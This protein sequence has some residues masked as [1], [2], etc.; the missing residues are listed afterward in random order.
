MLMR[1][2]TFN[3]WNLGP[4]APA[5][6]QVAKSIYNKQDICSMCK[7]RKADCRRSIETKIRKTLR[8]SDELVLYVLNL[9][10]GLL[11]QHIRSGK[12]KNRVISGR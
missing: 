3:S 12:S 11:E 8:T 5:S 6:S 7:K 2:S 9:N 1:G 4:Q 10:P